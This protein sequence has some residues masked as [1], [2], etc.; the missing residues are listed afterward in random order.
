MTLTLIPD[1]EAIVGTYL[2]EHPAVVA[3]GARVAGR[4]PSAMSAPWVRLTQLN[5]PKSPDSTPE[6][7]IHF[8]FQLDAYAGDTAM[9][10]HDGQAE[11]SLLGRT[12]R[13]ALVDMPEQTFDDVVV[14]D[15]QIVSMARIPDPSAGE[16]ARERVVITATVRMHAR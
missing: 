12:V 4:T 5:A 11:A 3:L 10:A 1:A 8:L 7:L 6:H 9:R 2:R 13:A 14:A 16:P 15:A